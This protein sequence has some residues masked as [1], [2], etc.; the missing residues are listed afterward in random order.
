MDR[1]RR[2]YLLTVAQSQENPRFFRSTGFVN[3]EMVANHSG[4]CFLFH[5][6]ASFLDAEEDE[7]LFRVAERVDEGAGYPV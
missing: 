4:N 2:I 3:G 5:N 6:T 7:K 1:D